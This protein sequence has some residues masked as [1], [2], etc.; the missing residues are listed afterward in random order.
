[1]PHT[2]TKLP[3][4]KV[5]RLENVDCAYCGVELSSI[6][7]DKDHVIGRRF[8]PKGKLDG[9]WNLLLNSCKRCN[10]KKGD[11]EDDISAITMQPD[12]LGRF[13]HNDAKAIED[14]NRKARN[15]FSR[16][17]RKVVGES[18]EQTR[19]R[20]PFGDGR[21]I[22]FGFIRQPQ[23]DDSRVFDLA[24][25]HIGA[26][27]YWVTFQDVT[28]RGSSLLGGFYPLLVVYRSDWGNWTIVEFAEVVANWVPRV[29]AGSAEG[30]Y[31]VALKKHPQA[32]C[33]S[34][35]LEWNHSLR[36]VGFFGDHNDCQEVIAKLPS[37]QFKQLSNKSGRMLRYREE[38]PLS[39]HQ[40]DKLFFWQEGKS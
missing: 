39:N 8:V 13:A 19:L 18:Q 38:T 10:G 31:K 16:R 4:N 35:A 36:V 26:F 34:W 29:M 22:S 15:S 9:C 6:A 25:M 28:K 14:A 1:M 11:L 2:L 30:F 21:S 12:V 33:W 40:E 20:M 5:I 24:R 23:V 17:T 32:F 27:F 3:Q 37:P 7:S